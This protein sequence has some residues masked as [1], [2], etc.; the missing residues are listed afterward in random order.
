MTGLS[1]SGDTASAGGGTRGRRR[2]KVAPRRGALSA[3]MVPP[4]ASAILRT[5]ASPSPVP[6]VLVVKNGVKISFR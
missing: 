1:T 5:M 6:L 3:V 2:V 4:W